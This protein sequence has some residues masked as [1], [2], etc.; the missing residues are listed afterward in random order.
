MK[1]DHHFAQKFLIYSQDGGIII[2]IISEKALFA[3]PSTQLFCRFE[4]CAQLSIS[5]VVYSYIFKDCE[6]FVE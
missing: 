3:S 1:F 2:I 4:S 6:S 5:S